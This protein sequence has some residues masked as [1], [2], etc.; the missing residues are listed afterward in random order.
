GQ[1]SARGDTKTSAVI[2]LPIEVITV[3]P[4]QPRRFFKDAELQSLASS[5]KVDGVIQPITVTRTETAGKYMLIAGERRL[6][7]S[8]LAGLEKIPAIIREPMTDQEQLRVALIENIQRQDLNVLEEAEAYHAL[9]HDFGLTQ[10]QCAD[11]VGKER[12]TVANILRILQLPREVQDD[13]AEGR[14][15]MG[16]G[17]ALLAL[18]DKK[19]ILR[20]RDVVIKRGLNVRQT[21]QLCKSQKASERLPPSHSEKSADLMYIA[22]G[23]RATLRTKVKLIGDGNRGR[24]E[25]A[26]FSAAE[27]ERLMAAMGHKIG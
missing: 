23:L 2:E 6:R 7:A 17:R 26:Y 9:I 15:S 27:L 18:E 13:L 19:T 25:I 5:I 16:H 1:N 24:I 12:S 4:H 20:A 10:E 14:L 22:D 11:K 3:N 8:K 21:E